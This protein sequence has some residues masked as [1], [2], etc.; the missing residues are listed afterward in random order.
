MPVYPEANVRV[1]PFGSKFV[2]DV[3]VKVALLTD[4]TMPVGALNTTVQTPDA[5]VF[6]EFVERVIVVPEKAVMKVPTAKAPDVMLIP[7]TGVYDPT[8]TPVI[9]G[10]P[11]VNTPVQDVLFGTPLTEAVIDPLGIIQLLNTIFDPAPPVPVL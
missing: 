3:S 7:T 4:P 8:T 1:V 9:V 2:S 11:V 5:A 6:V 10:E